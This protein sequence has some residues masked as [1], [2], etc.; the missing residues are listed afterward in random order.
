MMKYL[1]YCDFSTL[2]CD[3][4]QFAEFLQGYTEHYE[5]RGFGIWL[6]EIDDESSPFYNDLSSIVQD[7]ETAGYAD[8]DS[9]VYAVQYSVLT[10]RHPGFSESLHVD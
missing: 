5:N 7:L 6:V 4:K 2:K 8:E 9:I 10:C 1:I 3:F